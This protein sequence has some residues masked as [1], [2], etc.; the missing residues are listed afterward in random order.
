MNRSVEQQGIEIKVQA[1]QASI[2][3]VQNQEQ[4]DR[5]GR[6][7]DVAL[8][9]SK[10]SQDETAVPKAKRVRRPIGFLPGCG[11]AG[12]LEGILSKEKPAVYSEG[13]LDKFYHEIFDKK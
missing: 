3:A 2:L 4:L 1:D 9:I 13:E 7:L 5:I 11:P 12:E 10:K 8:V 6:K